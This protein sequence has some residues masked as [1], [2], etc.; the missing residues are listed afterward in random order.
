[1]LSAVGPTLSLTDCILQV[2]FDPRR[3]AG[4]LGSFARLVGERLVGGSGS[5]VG[6]DNV[7]ERMI[8]IVSFVVLCL[9]VVWCAR[10]CV[11]VFVCLPTVFVSVYGLSLLCVCLCVCVCVLVCLCVCLPV[12]PSVRPSVCMCARVGCAGACVC[13]GVQG[14][15]CVCFPCIA[16]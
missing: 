15:V 2:P 14:S 9:C 4:S 13:M 6:G 11:D 10:A 16:M 3:S 12:C 8:C 1:M 7:W 5:G